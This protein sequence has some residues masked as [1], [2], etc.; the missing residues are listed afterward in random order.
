MLV[1]SCYFLFYALTP[2]FGGDQLGLVGA[3]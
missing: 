3:D 2:F 1:F